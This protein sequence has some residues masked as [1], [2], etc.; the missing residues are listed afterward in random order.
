MS[1]ELLPCRAIT[2]FDIE[3]NIENVTFTCGN[4]PNTWVAEKESSGIQ[5]WIDEDDIHSKPSGE[6]DLD[7]HLPITTF[8]LKGDNPYDLMREIML[9]CQC[10]VLTEDDGIDLY[11]MRNDGEEEE[12]ID[13]IAMDM[14]QATLNMFGLQMEDG[15]R[16]VEKTITNEG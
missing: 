12:Q 9:Q 4:T 2:M 10:P 6:F 5:L 15:G 11:Y 8:V 14:E 1:K 7:K 3:R 16:I 13:K